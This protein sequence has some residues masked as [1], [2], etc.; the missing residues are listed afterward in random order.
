MTEKI[1]RCV[2]C[3]MPERVP[4][5]SLDEEGVC[6]FC[7]EFEEITYLGREKLEEVIEEARGGDGDYDC[8]VPMSGGRDSTY[9]LYVAR[10]EYDLKTLAVNFNNEFNHEQARINIRMACEITGADFISVRS[11]NDIG[12]NLVQSLLKEELG[13]GFS[14]R[15][16]ICRAC[17]YGIKAVPYS[18]AEKHGVKLILYAGSQEENVQGMIDTVMRAGG[19]TLKRKLLNRWNRITPK[20]LRVK[21][22]LIKMKREFPVTGNSPYSKSI[23]PELKTPGIKEI[24]LFNYIPWDRRVITSTITSELGWKKTAGHRSSWRNDCK[25]HQYINY[26]FIH[27]YGCS[28]DCFGYCRMIMTGK[29]AREK[30]LEQEEV[31]LESYEKGEINGVNIKQLLTEDVG[32]SEKEARMVMTK[33]PK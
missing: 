28:R 2:K 33:K 12:I 4:G 24:H 14:R 23:R 26:D 13:L 11:E 17:S 22:N 18:E 8:I 7:R 21:R 32:L 25:L 30:A 20:H 3:I 29:M 9:A 1:K 16:N 19:V 31:L 6:N 15:P 5:V 10:K 27:R